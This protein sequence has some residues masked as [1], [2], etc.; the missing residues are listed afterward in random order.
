MPLP[1][2]VTPTLPAS[3]VANMLSFF[4][5]FLTI[6]LLKSCGRG[7]GRGDAGNVLLIAK[8]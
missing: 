4:L 8:W 7:R 1:D 2:P 3:D 6:F 5:V